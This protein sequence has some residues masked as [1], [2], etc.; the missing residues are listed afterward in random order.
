M[1]NFAAARTNENEEMNQLIKTSRPYSEKDYVQKEISRV[2]TNN[3]CE[4][5]PQSNMIRYQK[6][7]SGIAFYIDTNVQLTN[8]I[9]DQ[10][11]ELALILSNLV[12]Q[13][14]SLP[15]ETIHLFRDVDSGEFCFK[16]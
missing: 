16:S 10:A 14:F 9:L 5:V 3:S 12:P 4:F 13:I 6:L 11:Q 1:T 7:L 8:L 2:E 15:I